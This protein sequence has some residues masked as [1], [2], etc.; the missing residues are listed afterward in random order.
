M[1]KSTKLFCVG[2]FFCMVIVVLVFILSNSENGDDSIMI[3]G[4]SLMFALLPAGYGISAG[5]DAR[6]KEKR[7][8]FANLPKPLRDKILADKEIVSVKIVS[9]STDTTTRGSVTSSVA[10]GVIG[11][12]LFGP[13]GMIAGAATPKQKTVGTET[14]ITF[15][16]R[17]ASGRV[18]SETV[19][20]DSL[21]Y[22]ELVKHIV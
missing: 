2:A 9:S 20:V 1:K 14:K 15:A 7:E 8:E 16:V 19:V 10:R 17:Y 13:I 4:M 11:G 18:S 22:K 6:A 5:F 21:R 3:Y 12:A